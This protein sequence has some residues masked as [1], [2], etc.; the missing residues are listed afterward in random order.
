[1]SQVDDAA[2]IFGIVG[3]AV[4]ASLAVQGV[5]LARVA[6]RLLAGQGSG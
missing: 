2:Q 6:P 1:M 5:V 3:V 4:L